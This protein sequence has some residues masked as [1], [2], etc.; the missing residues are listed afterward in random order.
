MAP[1]VCRKPPIYYH[2]VSLFV[3]FLFEGL[4]LTRARPPIFSN[5]L[6]FPKYL[7]RKPLPTLMM[8]APDFFIVLHSQQKLESGNLKMESTSLRI[9]RLL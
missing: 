9:P 5:I 4:V 2:V 3:T 6:T 1:I 7:L 8:D